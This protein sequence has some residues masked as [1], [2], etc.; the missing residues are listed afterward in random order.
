MSPPHLF[1]WAN[2]ATVIIIST[3]INTPGSNPARNSAPTD[4]LAIIA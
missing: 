2:Q 3:A 1:L 4:T